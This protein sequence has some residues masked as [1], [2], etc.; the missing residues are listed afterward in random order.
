M[1]TLLVLLLVFLPIATQAQALSARD[2]PDPILCLRTDPPP[3]RPPDVSPSAHA[4]PDRAAPVTPPTAQPPVDA[5]AAELV[6]ATRLAPLPCPEYV[7]ALAPGYRRLCGVTALD[8]RTATSLIDLA[9]GHRERMDVADWQ[10]TP[11][12]APRG[13]LRGW[14]CSGCLYMVVVYDTGPGTVVEITWG[15][16]RPPED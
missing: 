16:L 14:I 6:D 4:A 9:V 8:A 5:V 10:S 12:D 7:G 3:S 2:V 1:R 11:T 13:Q 15:T